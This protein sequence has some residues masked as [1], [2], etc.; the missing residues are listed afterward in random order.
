MVSSDESQQRENRPPESQQKL[1]YE[2]SNLN[3]YRDMAG[4]LALDPPMPS[5]QEITWKEPDDRLFP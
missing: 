2:S 4:L 1:P 3:I 5:L